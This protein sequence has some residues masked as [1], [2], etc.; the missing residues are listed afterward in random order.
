[1]ELLAVK[2]DLQTFL[3]S[4]NF[5]SIPI[6]MYKIEALTYLRKTKGTKNQKMTILSKE[7]WEML[8]SEQIM[9]TM[10]YYPAH[11]TKWR[12]WNLVAKRIHPNGSSVNRPFAISA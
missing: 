4:Q 9:I 12:T 1:M 11:S 3:K 7:I 10:K 8:I 2:I 5:T 6:Q